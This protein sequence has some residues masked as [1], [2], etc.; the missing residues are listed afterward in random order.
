MTVAAYSLQK[1]K[2]KGISIKE[3]TLGKPG[4]VLIILLLAAAYGL[5]AAGFVLPLSV[6]VVFML[7]TVLASVPSFLKILS[8]KSYREVYQDILNQ[9]LNQIDAAKKVK[10]NMHDKNISADTKISSGKSGFE[11]LNEL[12]IKRH[13]NILWKS[14]KKITLVCLCLI[15]GALLAFYLLP[16]IKDKTNELLLTYLPYMVI[17]MYAINRGTGFTTALFMNCDHS[18]LTYSFY[19]QPKFIL[20][21]FQIRLREIMKVNLLPA[22]V[23]GIGLALLLYFSGGT[24]NAL[25]YLVLIMSVPALSVFF[26]V[27]YLTIYYLLQPYNMGTEMKSATYQIVHTIT[28]VVCLNIIRFK[29]MTIVFGLTTITF[30]VL[31]CIVASVLVYKFAPKTF[32]LRV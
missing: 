2:K 1:Y 19:K 27:H 11:Y 31:Y 22:M 4:W 3:N 17:V 21:L 18:L 20:K 10:R 13:Q 16:E 5:P 14:T 6:A 28:Y 32:R 30:C 26:S 9:F 12:F 25:N 29:M 7:L 23:I 24:D 15:L 8:F